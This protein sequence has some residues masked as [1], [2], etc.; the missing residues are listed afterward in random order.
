M[1]RFRFYTLGLWFLMAVF[2]IPASVFGYESGIN[3]LANQ[4]V[5]IRPDIGPSIPGL[6]IGKNGYKVFNPG[7]IKTVSLD[8]PQGEPPRL[9]AQVPLT[10]I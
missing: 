3:I 4:V 8:S 9:R 10:L 7:A 5:E 6:K 2:M 1:F